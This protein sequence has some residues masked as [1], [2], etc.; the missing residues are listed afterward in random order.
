[1]NKIEIHQTCIEILLAIEH[2]EKRRRLTKE[3]LNGATGRLFPG[4]AAEMLHSIDIAGKCIE[5]L[6]E[7]YIKQLEQL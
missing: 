3:S 5:R 1:M 2:F 7:R 6:R 4:L